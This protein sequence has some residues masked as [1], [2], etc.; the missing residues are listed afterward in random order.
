MNLLKMQSVKDEERR[1]EEKRERDAEKKK[2]EDDREKERR[3]T[4]ETM[5]KF[6]GE[7]TTVKTELKEIKSNQ[8]KTD[9]N[10]ATLTEKMET[11]E[12]ELKKM[13]QPTT[14]KPSIQLR[15][16]IPPFP[17]SCSP[18]HPPGSLPAAFQPSHSQEDEKKI[19]SIVKEARKTIGFSPISEDDIRSVKDENKIENNEE[20]LEAAIKDFMHQEMSI[21]KEVSDKLQIVKI[22]RP[23]N[24]PDSEKLFAEF[25]EDNM[26]A[27]VYKY[28]KKLNRNSGV[29]TFIPP[30]FKARAEDL[31][32]CAYELRHGE[33]EFSTKIKW[34][35]GDLILERKLKSNPNARYNSVTVKDLPPVNLNPPPPMA[36][37]PNPSSSPA[38]GRRDRNKRNRSI[39]PTHSSPSSKTSRQEDLG[40]VSNPHN[41]GLFQID[42]FRSPAGVSSN[43]SPIIRKKTGT[44]ASRSLGFH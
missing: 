19:Y 41:K 40:Q 28:V 3:V 2:E 4:H 26:P 43:P 15:G 31:E 12:S 6:I 23:V 27:T 11:L 5:N 24:D 16:S 39:T 20:A 18:I 14:T 42:S 29:H 35:Y 36:K 13:K 8:T 9:Q 30:S 25:S 33:P 34:G 32:K 44:E 38:P 10:Y 22:F 37:M 17:Q 1:A 7:V 21:P